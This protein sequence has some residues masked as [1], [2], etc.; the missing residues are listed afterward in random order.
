[1][2]KILAIGNSFSQDATHFLHQIAEAGG[3]ATKVVNL[4][5]G[6]CSLETHWNN[7]E[8]HF[9]AYEYELNGEP[10]GRKV[11]IRE[12]LLEDEWDFITLQQVSGQSGILES[13]T[14]Y[15]QKLS[16][17]ITSFAPHAKQLIHQTWAYETDSAHPDFAFYNSNQQV[18][19][20]ALTAAYETIAKSMGLSVIPCGEVIQTLRRRPPFD[21]PHGGQSLC[22]DGFHLDLVYGRYAAAA[23]WYKC[24][25]K[26]NILTNSFVPSDPESGDI[27]MEYLAVIKG[28]VFQIIS[29]REND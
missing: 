9:P 10:I 5:I 7:A 18:M 3:V 1:M 22:R 20:G 28:V 14:P 25:L 8:Q 6:G 19:F 11:S 21:Y 13:Y 26:G 16:A 27:N 4:Y 17:F 12:A 15:L 23:T 29:G 2:I 24:L